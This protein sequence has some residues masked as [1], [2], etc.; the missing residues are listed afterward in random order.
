MCCVYFCVVVLVTRLLLEHVLY[1]RMYKVYVFA[2]KRGK[3]M[4]LE[5]TEKYIDVMSLLKTLNWFQIYLLCTL[6]IFQNIFFLLHVYF[7]FL[8]ESLIPCAPGRSA[9]G[10][11]KYY[12]I[13]AK[14]EWLQNVHTWVSNFRYTVIICSP[15]IKCYTRS[16][17][18][19]VNSCFGYAYY[20]DIPHTN[21]FY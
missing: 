20:I 9:Y 17:S 5:S 15:C 13:T 4:Y 6:T 1:K 11:T 12:K 18:Q 14:T 10:H 8:F 21:I 7:Y 19:L 16:D 3:Y 2:Y